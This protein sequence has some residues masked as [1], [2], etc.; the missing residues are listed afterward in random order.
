MAETYEQIDRPY[1]DYLERES[2]SLVLAGGENDSVVFDS[3]VVDDSQGA[4]T[5][6]T[7]GTGETTETAVYGEQSF[8]DVWIDSFIR[9][10][11]WSVSP[12]WHVLQS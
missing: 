7:T 6:T 2:D 12:N 11:N 8:S 10:K 1:G 4:G 5:T 3:A 9:S